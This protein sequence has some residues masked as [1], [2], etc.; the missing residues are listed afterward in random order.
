MKSI[1]KNIE[2]Q[3]ENIVIIPLEIVGVVAIVGVLG[4]QYVTCTGDGWFSAGC[5]WKGEKFF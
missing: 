2:E 1:G 4:F 3:A 5:M